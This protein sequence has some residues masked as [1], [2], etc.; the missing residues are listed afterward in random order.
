MSDNDWFENAEHHEV[1]VLTED[2]LLVALFKNAAGGGSADLFTGLESESESLLASRSESGVGM[3]A[4]RDD[5]SPDP[6]STF[7]LS[8]VFLSTSLSWLEDA[9]PSSRA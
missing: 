2:M 3:P 7:P 1:V 4:V 5:S 6:K 8:T 9:K